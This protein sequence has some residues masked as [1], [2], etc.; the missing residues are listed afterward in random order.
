LFCT[1]E[2]KRSRSLRIFALSRYQ[3]YGLNGRVTAAWRLAG[4]GQKR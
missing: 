3:R 1:M 2:F 4:I